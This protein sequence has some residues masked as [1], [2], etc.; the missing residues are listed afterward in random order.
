MQY[1]I[2]C[3]CGES[4]TV[5]ETAAGTSAPCRCGRTVVIPSLR[6]LRRLAGVPE[7][8][9]SPEMAVEAL[10]LAGKLPEEDHC[11]L[12]GTETSATVCCKTECERARVRGGQPPLWAY[13]LGYLTFGWLGVLI[14]EL[15]AGEEREWGK[16]RVFPLPL[17]VCDACRR[18]LT[19]PA[20]VKAAL[21]RVPLYQRLLAKYPRARVSL[22]AS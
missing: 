15:T 1:R 8:S 2:Y 22:P 4:V 10:L 9:P 12:C 14:A 7:S 19:N 13:L 5:A 11:V 3:E 16:D 17:R 6:E 20:A 18:G 21:C